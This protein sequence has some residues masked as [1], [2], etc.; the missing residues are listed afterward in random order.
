MGEKVKAKPDGWKN[1]EECVPFYGVVIVLNYSH[2]AFIVGKNSSRNKY[3]Y[4]G[5]NQGGSKPGTQKI[6]YG[7]VTIGDEFM[8]MKPKKYV[9]SEREKQLEEYLIDKDGS[10]QTTR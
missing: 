2:V 7:S 4:I 10:F 6:Q 3:V 1:G 8:I 9:I 5:G